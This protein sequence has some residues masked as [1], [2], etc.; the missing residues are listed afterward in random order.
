M[1]HPA[2]MTRP[3]A[4]A[5]AATAFALL[6]AAQGLYFLVTGV[7]PLVSMETFEAVTGEKTDRW[8]V[9]TV[10]VPVAAVGLVLLLAAWRARPSAEVALLAVGCA[11]GLAAIDV[12]YVSRGVILPIYLADAAL[13]AVFILA[14]LWVGLR[15]RG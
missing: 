14:W 3:R 12:V 7:W 1:S 6:C 8:L 15:A 5:G 2:T 9:H 4:A 13:E 10:G 11:A